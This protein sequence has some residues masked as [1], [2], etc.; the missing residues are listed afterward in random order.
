MEKEG[1]EEGKKGR[2]VTGMR[3]GRR[4]KGIGKVGKWESEQ[5]RKE[6]AE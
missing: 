3:E 4:E 5:E 2:R 1:G 6:N